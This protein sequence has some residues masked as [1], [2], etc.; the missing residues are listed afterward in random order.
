MYLFR[1]AYP[2]PS[3][4]SLIGTCWVTNNLCLVFG[5]FLLCYTPAHYTSII[6][7]YSHITWNISVM[8]MKKKWYTDSYPSILQV[9]IIPVNVTGRGSNTLHPHTCRLEILDYSVEIEQIAG[10]N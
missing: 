2:P 1:L 9:G 3:Y 7:L 4:P 8:V 6:L 10:K 5:L